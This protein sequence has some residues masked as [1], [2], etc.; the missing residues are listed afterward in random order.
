MTGP[1]YTPQEAADLVTE[2]GSIRKAAVAEGVGYGTM[3]SAYSKAV[4]QGFARPRTHADN[5]SEE[6]KTRALEGRVQPIRTR[7]R[8]TPSS[9]VKR[10]IITSAQNNTKLFDPGWGNLLALRDYYDAELMVSRFTYNLS[11]YGRGSVKPGKAKKSGDEIWYDPDIEPYVVDERTEI[12]P[13]LVFCGEINVLPTGKR[14][15]SGFET[16][17]GRKSGIFPHAKVAMESVASGKYEPT[18][19]NYTTGAVTLRNYIQKKAG[20]VAEFHH[21]YAALLVEVEPCGDWF[22]RQLHMDGEGTIYDWDVCVQGGNV[23]VGNPVEAVTWADVHAKQMSDVFKEACWGP[24][25]MI[26]ELRPRYQFFHDLFDHYARN[27]HERGNPHR[28]FERYVNGDD[29][30]EDELRLTADAAKYARR[31]WCQSVVVDSNHDNALE[32]WVRETT[33]DRDPVNAIFWHEASL[34]KYRAIERGDKGFHMLEWALRRHGLVEERFLREDEPFV[35]CP[36]RSGG[37]ECGM[38]GHLGPNGS[39][40]SVNSFA[41]MGRKKNI[42]HLHRAGIVDDVYVGGKSGDYEY[43]AGPSAGSMSNVVTYA[44]GKRTIVTIW[45]GKC[46]AFGEE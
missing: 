17:T 27:H 32:K 46:R 23:T 18:K 26:D 21:S 3:Q 42:G 31:P 8:K 11:A 7:V 13:G 5:K 4:S 1:F 33:P 24:G 29:D 34:A 15:L 10:Y 44:N 37:V 38:H 40:G 9:G 43:E 36:D 45:R 19:F 28:M 14:P 20:Q 30:I 2:H 12:A 35:I 6:D 22:V 41:K 39:K 16:Y 25:G